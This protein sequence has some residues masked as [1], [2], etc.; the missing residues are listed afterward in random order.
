MF[1]NW[2]KMYMEDVKVSSSLLK[3]NS[4]HALW[5]V[6]L[7]QNIVFK[8]IQYSALTHLNLILPVF[9]IYPAAKVDSK[10]VQSLHVIRNRKWHL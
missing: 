9:S 10:A 3:T 8:S 1:N 4:I 7:C 5:Q 6:L 2:A